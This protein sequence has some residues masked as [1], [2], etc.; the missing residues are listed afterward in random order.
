MIVSQREK[1]NTTEVSDF[2]L[3]YFDVRRVLDA[4]GTVH[5]S[6]QGFRRYLFP[7]Q[8]VRCFK[9]CL[10]TGAIGRRNDSPWT[11]GRITSLQQSALEGR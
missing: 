4:Y 3:Q 1:T 7:Q 10:T 9:R 5:F 2:F 6:S 8:V 11:E